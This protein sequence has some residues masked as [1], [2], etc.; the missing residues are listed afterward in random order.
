[1]EESM[2]KSIAAL[3]ALFL[4]AFAVNGFAMGGGEQQEQQ[5]G[6]EERAGEQPADQQWGEQQQMQQTFT[7]TVDR[8]GD[9]W[10]LIMDGTA[11]ELEVDDEE[12]VR[13]MMGQE[14][15]I[16]GTLDGQTIQAET[17]QPSG[18]GQQPMSGQDYQQQPGGQQQ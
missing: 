3:I 12:Q 10:V 14:V 17:I 6:V 5:P 13:G 2:K 4:L 7:G 8:A 16:Q 1:M 11:Y 9:N 15:E 18:Q